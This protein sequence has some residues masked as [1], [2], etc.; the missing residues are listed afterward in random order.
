M[1]QTKAFQ[2]QMIFMPPRYEDFNAN[3]SAKTVIV[4]EH[5]SVEDEGETENQLFISLFLQFQFAS[6]YSGTV[7]LLQSL[8]AYSFL[9]KKKTNYF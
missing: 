2:V 9:S 8:M 5:L 4:A 6:K 3:A 1:L 7:N